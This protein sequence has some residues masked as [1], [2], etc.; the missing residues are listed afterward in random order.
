MQE[1]IHEFLIIFF[2]KYTFFSQN[3]D[4]PVKSS[5]KKPAEQPEKAVPQNH[6]VK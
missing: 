6:T 4:F 5:T 2:T 3:L 1:I